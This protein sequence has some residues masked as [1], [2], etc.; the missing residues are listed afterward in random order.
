MPYRLHS[1]GRIRRWLGRTLAGDEAQG[2]RIWRR[3]VHLFGLLALL[4]YVVPGDF[5]VVITTRE[6][7]YL[8]V[9]LVIA[10]ELARHFAGLELPTIR[11][12]EEHRIASYTY[13]GVAIAAALLLFPEAIG[14]VVIVG[15]AVIDPLIGELRVSERFRR[16]YPGLPTIGYAAIA[17]FGFALL[18]PWPL[19]EVLALA[20]LAAVV[21]IISERP[22]NVWID[23]DFAMTMAP[24]L[25]LLGVTYLWHP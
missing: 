23:D 8:L 19:P 9:V 13:Y 22:K 7:V 14:A 2:E 5:F 4:Y 25:V 24:A 1:G 3:I 18:G 16:F 20:V 6:I 21:A 17:A 10:I 15:T 11:P 12:F